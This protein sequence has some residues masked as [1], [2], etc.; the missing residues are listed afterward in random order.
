MNEN[1]T[2]ERHCGCLGHDCDRC[3]MRPGS[4]TARA[5]GCT[6]PVLDNGHGHAERVVISWGCP[7]HGLEAS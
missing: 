1:C 3:H 5:Q 6:C 2:P 7:V 4:D